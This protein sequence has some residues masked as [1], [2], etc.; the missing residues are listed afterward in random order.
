M[1]DEVDAAPNF[2]TI[3]SR[4]A[5][6]S[7][8]FVLMSFSVMGLVILFCV[9]GQPLVNFVHLNVPAVVTVPVV[10]AVEWILVVRVDS[11]DTG[12]TIDLVL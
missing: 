2:L 7:I 10:V 9:H 11:L 4:N 8:S 1:P 12:G 6:L 3:I 5:L